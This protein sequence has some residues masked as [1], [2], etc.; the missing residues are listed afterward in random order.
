MKRGLTILIAEDDSNDADLLQA[1]IKRAGF[2]NP[3]RVVENG[4][5]AIAYLEGRAPYDDR[6]TYPL[7]SLIFTDLKMPMVGGFELLQ[8]F[9]EHDMARVAPIIV[10]SG[11]ALRADIEKAYR[12]GANSYIAKPQGLDGWVAIVKLV[13]DYWELCEKPSE[14]VKNIGQPTL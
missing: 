12:L 7:P 11:S 8:W 2:A 10:L 5:R 4:D 9:R 14:V 3:V 13:A 6:G 1:A